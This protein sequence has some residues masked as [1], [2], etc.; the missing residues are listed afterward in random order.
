MPAAM[1][2]CPYKGIHVHEWFD[3]DVENGD[4]DDIYHSVTCL[5]CQRVHLV[6]PKTG[7]VL[8]ARDE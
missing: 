5:A 8:G 7:A 1:F 2:L 3:D 4:G 6:N